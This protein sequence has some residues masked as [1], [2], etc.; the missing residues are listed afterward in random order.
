MGRNTISPLNL[1]TMTLKQLSPGQSPPWVGV[2]NKYDLK[3]ETEEL[4]AAMMQRR[5]NL[6]D[7]GLGVSMSPQQSTLRT[8]NSS[9]GS[10]TESWSAHTSGDDSES[11]NLHKVVR[12]ECMSPSSFSFSG[13]RCGTGLSRLSD[14]G[15]SWSALSSFRA[16]IITPKKAISLGKNKDGKYG[17][18]L[19]KQNKSQLSDFQLFDQS[20]DSG[21]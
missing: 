2:E 7:A 18:V 4:F 19:S 17:R 15:D 13:S 11:F 3:S 8:L 14:E 20:L 1:K 16:K 12:E 10:G 6:S 21:P 5:K 9:R